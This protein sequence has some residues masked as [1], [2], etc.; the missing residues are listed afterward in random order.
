MGRLYAHGGAVFIASVIS[1]WAG[2]TLMA[3]QLLIWWI[4][5]LTCIL[6]ITCISQYLKLYAKR[7]HFEKKPITQTWA[8]HPDLGS[9]TGG[10]GA[11]ACA[12]HQ[13]DHAE[14]LLGCEGV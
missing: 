11:D 13:L 14:Y 7:K 12:E 9:H 10:E 6:T 2:Y 1:S 3:V 8:H 4:M 5:Q